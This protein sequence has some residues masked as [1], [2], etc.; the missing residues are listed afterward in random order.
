MNDPFVA[1]DLHGLIREEAMRHIDTTLR[2]AGSGVYQ[3]RL[4]HGYHRRIP[5]DRVD[6]P[7]GEYAVPMTLIVDGDTV[8]ADSCDLEYFDNYREGD[9]PLSWFQHHLELM[10]SDP[11]LI[12]PYPLVGT[13]KKRSSPSGS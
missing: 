9:T 11:S 1:I 8:F 5:V 4:V 2:D 10:D 7:S 13:S 6:D 12:P 3:V